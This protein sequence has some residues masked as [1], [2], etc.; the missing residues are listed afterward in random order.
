MLWCALALI[1]TCVH[2]LVNNVVLFLD[3]QH[4]LH[5]SWEAHLLVAQSSP[6]PRAVVLLHRPIPRAVLLRSTL[7][8]RRLMNESAASSSNPDEASLDLSFL[9]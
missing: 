1:N 5:F 8:R 7:A 4:G 9:G 6:P 3:F 2:S